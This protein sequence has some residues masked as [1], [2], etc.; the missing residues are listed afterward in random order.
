MGPHD[1]VLVLHFAGASC[2]CHVWTAGLWSF[3]EASAL[4]N[5]A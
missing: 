4:A 3:R 1:L 2:V 5:A